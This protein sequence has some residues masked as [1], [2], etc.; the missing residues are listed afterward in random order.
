[1]RRPRADV[2]AR[3]E[4]AIEARR[5]ERQ[6]LLEFTGGG[7]GGGASDNDE[8][9]SSDDDHR[10]DGYEYLD[11]TADVQLHSWGESLEKAMENLVACMFNYMTD[12]RGIRPQEGQERTVTVSA[13]DAPSLV[14]AFLQEWLTRFHEDGF[15]P[16]RVRVLGSVDRGPARWTVEAGAEGEAFDPSRHAPGTEVKAVTYSNLQVVD[17]SSE[18]EGGRCDIW[19][20]VDI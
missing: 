15:V 12:L 7:R 13:H 20:I 5:R 16:R 8:G 6:Q 4:A 19:V 9:Y 11:H 17:R 1:M 18:G 2:E 3:I 14:F 10:A